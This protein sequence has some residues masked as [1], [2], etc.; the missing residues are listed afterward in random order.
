MKNIAV[1]GCTLELTPASS[2]EAT[3][4]I[5]TDPSKKVLAVGKGCYFGDLEISI[6]GYTGGSI[7]VTGSGSGNGTLSGSSTKYK[8]EG[9]AAVLEGDSVTIT[10]NGQKTSGSSTIATTQDVTVKISDAGQ[11]NNKSE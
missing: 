3:V 5:K 10:V 2:P 1:K 4:T 7:D 8:I 11:T 6:T 9:A